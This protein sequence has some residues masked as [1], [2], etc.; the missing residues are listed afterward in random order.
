MHENYD[1]LKNNTTDPLPPLPSFAFKS[2]NVLG[3][4]KNIPD[5]SCQGCCSRSNKLNKDIKVSPPVFLNK[6]LNLMIKKR[7]LKGIT[8][9]SGLTHRILPAMGNIIFESQ[10]EDILTVP[11][12]T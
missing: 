8:K 5:L 9:K 11:R 7:D 1:I 10:T 3:C 12:K 4:N 2:E 6:N